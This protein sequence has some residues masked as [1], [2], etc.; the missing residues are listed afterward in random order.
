MDRSY[1]DDDDD[2]MKAD[3]ST[4]NRI[5]KRGAASAGGLGGF[6]DRLGPTVLTGALVAAVIVNFVLRA[7]G[8]RGGGGGD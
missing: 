3:K 2:D 4:N 5:R 6:D 7:V 1:D 8:D